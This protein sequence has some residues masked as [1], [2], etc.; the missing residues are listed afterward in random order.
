MPWLRA[1]ILNDTDI[2]F[3]AEQ[4]PAF[5][6]H[7]PNQTKP[8]QTFNKKDAFAILPTGFNKILKYN[9]SLISKLNWDIPTGI[10][11]AT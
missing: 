5:K 9:L 4:T 6:N 7:Q 1:S 8:N 10:S 2:F 11:Q 3:E